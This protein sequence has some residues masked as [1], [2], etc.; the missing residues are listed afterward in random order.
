[1][2]LFSSLTAGLSICLALWTVFDGFHPA[3]LVIVPMWALFVLS[4]DRWILAAQPPDG[5]A[6]RLLRLL[7][8]LLIAIAIGFIVSE[9][10]LLY[11]FAPTLRGQVEL[12]RVNATAE[13][14]SRD[15][16]CNPAPGSSAAE[17]LPSYCGSYYL[18]VPNAELTAKLQS[19]AILQD[20]VASLQKTVDS[21]LDKLDFLEQRARLECNGQAGSGTT[22]QAGE[23][24]TCKRLRAEAD[25]Y[26][27]DLRIS[28]NTAKLGV[29]NDEITAA[30]AET[31]NLQRAFEIAREKAIQADPVLAQLRGPVGV[32]ERYQA[33][34]DLVLTSSFALLAEWA[35]RLLIVLVDSLPVL[36]RLLSGRTAYDQIVDQ[37][38]KLA[39]RTLREAADLEQQRAEA[40]ARL[41]L[42]RT[43][44]RIRQ[45]QHEQAQEQ[46]N[47]QQSILKGIEA[48]LHGPPLVNFDG[49]ISVVA[50]AGDVTLSVDERSVVTGGERQ[51]GLRV[52]IAPEALGAVTEQLSVTNGVE[53]PEVEFSI[54]VDS[55]RPSL[56]HAARTLTVDMPYGA[57]S[58]IFEFDLSGVELAGAPWIWVRVAQGRRTLQS[59]EFSIQATA[60]ADSR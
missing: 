51:F 27:E 19:V 16:E 30:Q 22:G 34:N 12:N 28:A 56:R 25:Q 38:A 29:L 13:R 41:D 46:V 35:L 2:L 59:I 53:A 18:A 20:Q 44:A 31:A 6:R 40:E 10:L 4:I 8:R 21:S 50:S 15:R 49:W 3:M 55:D 24:P 33:L 43:E 11:L 9:S 23:G 58:T 48:A 45:E 54:E 39:H 36:I 17:A 52:T 32:L 5:A 14:Q 26:R 47:L 57:A 60:S 1:M 42:A 7:P 37:R